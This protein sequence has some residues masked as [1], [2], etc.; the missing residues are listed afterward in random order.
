MKEDTFPLSSEGQFF[1]CSQLEFS[2]FLRMQYS[3]TTIV[4]KPLGANDYFLTVPNKGERSCMEYPHDIL[5]MEGTEVIL[6]IYTD[7][8]DGTKD[9]AT[10]FAFD[11]MISNTTA[12]MMV[13]EIDN[14]RKWRKVSMKMKDS[15][16]VKVLRY[17]IYFFVGIIFII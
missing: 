8:E 5:L 6:S 12:E 3:N 2:D 1:P 14:S 16:V 15:V 4:D 10:L 9:W 11:S 17:Q 13:I 7:N